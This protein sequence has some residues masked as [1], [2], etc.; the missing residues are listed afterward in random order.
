MIKCS[1]NKKKNKMCSLKCDLSQATILQ[2]II[3]ESAQMYTQHFQAGM[4]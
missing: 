1:K 3:L 2:M 4:P